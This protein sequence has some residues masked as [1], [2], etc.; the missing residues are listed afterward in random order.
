M[1]DPSLIA[2]LPYAASCWPLLLLVLLPLV[3]AGFS[4]RVRLGLLGALL[5]LEI[6]LLAQLLVWHH[7]GDSTVLG[8]RLG[9]YLEVHALRMD[10][11]LLLA[12]EQASTLL[13]LTVLALL[14]GRDRRA[15]RP[16]L[17]LLAAAGLSLMA[18]DIVIRGL[19]WSGMT[20]ASAGL[21]PGGAPGG[22]LR[23]LRLGL[24]ADGA[25]ALV[26][27]LGFWSLGGSFSV[28]RG[29]AP[30]VPDEDPAVPLPALE[31]RLHGAPS[32]SP[33]ERQAVTIGPTL[34]LREARAQLEARD[35]TGRRPLRERLQNKLFLGERLW[36]ALLGLLL[37]ASLLR[38]V[39]G[40]SAALS[41]RREATASPR[42]LVA[43]AALA[44]ALDV[45]ARFG[46]G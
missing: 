38:G 32:G 23:A 3:A 45:W 24:C 13:G 4:G 18:D 27:V 21:V 34:S 11:T 10:A 22:R 28:G 46:L 31:L 40:A 43:A 8:L 26:A 41:G 42:L 1:P 33:R 37:L 15:A 36:K 29:A 5:L 25:L 12:P 7:S 44:A 35:D 6:G 19:G 16:A 9:R 14:A 20:L 39:A 17:L 2:S 30:F